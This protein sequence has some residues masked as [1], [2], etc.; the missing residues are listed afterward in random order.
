MTSLTRDYE[1]ENE[2]EEQVFMYGLLLNSG[3]GVAATLPGYRLAFSHFATPVEDEDGTMYGAVITVDTA[4]LR[5]FD[6]VEGVREDGSG[7]YH[8]ERLQTSEGPAWVYL[9]NERYVEQDNP[10][11][12]H[13]V[14]GME[15]AYD[16]LGH[17]VRAYAELERAM[18]EAYGGPAD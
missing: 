7:Y 2:E 12:P 14:R 16:R 17:P 1:P 6:K 15:K 8:R 5:Y 13:Y 10:P 18:E 4:G 11:A 3:R 9:M